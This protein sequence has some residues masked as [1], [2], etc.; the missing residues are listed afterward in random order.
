MTTS[1]L[2]GT[3]A[4]LLNG[5]FIVGLISTAKS[6]NFTIQRC[7]K[8]QGMNIVLIINLLTKWKLDSSWYSDIWVFLFNCS[9]INEM[10]PTQPPLEDPIIP[11]IWLGDRWENSEIDRSDC[12]IYFLY[13]YLSTSLRG[14]KYPWTRNWLFLTTWIGFAHI[15]RLRSSPDCDSPRSHAMKMPHAMMVE[16]AA[17]VL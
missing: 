13:A 17:C 6:L 8:G 2:K 15:E 11:L 7:V 9:L 1:Y 12:K 16:N 10:R 3:T 5:Y 4:I 14:W